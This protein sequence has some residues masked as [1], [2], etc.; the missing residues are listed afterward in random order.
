MSRYV[1]P[2]R[3]ITV[4]VLKALKDEKTKTAARVEKSLDRCYDRD[5]ISIINNGGVFYFEGYIPKFVKEYLI[6][7][8]QSRFNL[9]YLLNLHA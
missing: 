7:F 8:I 1:M 2:E 9:Q 3:Y 5:E 6:K 4:D